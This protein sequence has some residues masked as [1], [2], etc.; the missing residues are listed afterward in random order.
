M[1]I[2]FCVL[3]AIVSRSFINSI[4]NKIFAE[5]QETRQDALAAKSQA[6]EAE[7]K[8]EEAKESASRMQKIVAQAC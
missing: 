1:L 2:G 7:T 6:G 5:L 3:A 8:S 4:S